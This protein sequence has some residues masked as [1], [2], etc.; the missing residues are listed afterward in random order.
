MRFSYT[1]GGLLSAGVVLAAPMPMPTP[2]STPFPCSYYSLDRKLT[3]TPARHPVRL[4]GQVAAGV[5]DGGDGGG[6]RQLRTRPV[7]DVGHHLGD[8]QHARV[9]AAARRHGRDRGVQLPADGGHL[10]Q[11]LRR[12]QVDGGVRRGHRPHGAAEERLDRMYSH[13]T[14][15]SLLI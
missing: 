11:P 7:P 15:S 12:R 2:V 8:V 3:K 1:L 4:V 13:F 14:Y 6:R 5:S 9:R 10:D